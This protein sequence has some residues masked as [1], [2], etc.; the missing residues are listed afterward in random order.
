MDP[1]LLF[2]L[3]STYPPSPIRYRNTYDEDRILFKPGISSTNTSRSNY[4]RSPDDCIYQMSVASQKG[5]DLDDV[6]QALEIAR[7][8]PE[9]TEQDNNQAL[10]QSAV[11]GIWKKLVSDHKGE[12]VMTR[13]EFA[14]F[15]YF[16]NRERRMVGEDARIARKARARY[17]SN[18]K[19]PLVN[20]SSR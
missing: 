6:L 20:D 3:I 10:L 13:E 19:G 15:N 9:D 12:Y 18:V 5:G 8:S 17:W 14:I 1:R 7:E 16:Q 11:D 2:D 4:V